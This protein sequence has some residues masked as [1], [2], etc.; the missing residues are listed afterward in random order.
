MSSKSAIV[1]KIAIPNAITYATLTTLCGRSFPFLF[2]GDLCFDKDNAG[3]ANVLKSTLTGAADVIAA[4]GAVHT[5]NAVDS[6]TVLI[7]GAV[8][9]YVNIVGESVEPHRANG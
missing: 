6:D 2:K 9:D 4:A 1:G 8:T 7:R 3:A 5:F